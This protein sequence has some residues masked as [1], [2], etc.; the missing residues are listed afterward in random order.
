[1]AL[2]LLAIAVWLGA[3][4]GWL[5]WQPLP[6][7]RATFGG[8]G[9]RVVRAI[10]APYGRSL[11]S[12]GMEQRATRIW[13]VDARGER[14]AFPNYFPMSFSPDG[15]TLLLRK[16]EANKRGDHLRFVDV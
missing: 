9:G 10:F 3:G 15:K 2:I 4:I 1:W 11:A 8:H 7:L 12:F 13:D 14:F 5:Y 16:L 6:P